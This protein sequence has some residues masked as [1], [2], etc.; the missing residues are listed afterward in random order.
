MCARGRST[1]IQHTQLIQTLYFRMEKAK[2]REEK[3]WFN[4]NRKEGR[5]Q[6]DLRLQKYRQKGNKMRK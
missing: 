3:Q 4:H 2:M 6:E 5:E 1:C